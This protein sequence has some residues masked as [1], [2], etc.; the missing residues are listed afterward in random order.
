MAS[1][2]SQTEPPDLA[3][4]GRV[5]DPDGA[6]REGR[7]E[8]RAIGA[9]GGGEGDA[10]R[11]AEQADLL[12]GLGVPDPDGAVPAGRGDPAAVGAERQADRPRPGGRPGSGAAARVPASQSWT[13]PPPVEAMRRPSGL[14][15]RPG[16][17]RRARAARIGPRVAASQ[18]RMAPSWPG[19]DDRR[20]V[21]EEGARRDPGG[22]GHRA[23]PARP[24]RASTASRCRP[25]SPRRSAGRRG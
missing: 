13:A 10:P 5:P 12:A 19:G 4:V 18:I 15:A 24:P 11:P 20:P 9:V 7:G 25:R 3:A 14:R 1:M 17:D 16:S 21:G 22:V 23:R 2:F 6:V 8:P